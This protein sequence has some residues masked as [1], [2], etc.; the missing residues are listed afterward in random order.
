ML[1]LRMILF[2][3]SFSL[4]Q[5]SISV[6]INHYENI[7]SLFEKEL[8]EEVIFLH[9]R[10]HKTEKIHIRYKKYQNFNALF[11]I[12][13]QTKPEEMLC[14]I[15][16]ISIT[17]ERLKKYDFSKAYF[18]NKQV[19][20][21]KKYKRYHAEQTSRISYTKNSLNEVVMKHFSKTENFIAVPYF[22]FYKRYQ[23]L[24][25]GI[26]DYAF[27][28]YIDQWIYKLKLIKSFDSYGIDR[29]GIIF[30]KNSTLKEKLDPFIN[31]YLKS[32]A[33][34]GLIKRSFGKAGI[35]FIQQNK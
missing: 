26:D 16:V 4:A 10:A 21:S 18:K 19:L 9:N 6:Y 32:P 20:L 23:N 22:D 12:L 28:D 35:Q 24:S 29:F 3:I 17:E 27:G 2:F 31:Y 5:D 30:P 33:Y 7:F 34:I 14:G 15:N 8:I 25:R 11:E 1:R 13:D